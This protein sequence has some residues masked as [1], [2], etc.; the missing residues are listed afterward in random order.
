M[1]VSYETAF[2]IAKQKVSHDLRNTSQTLHDDVPCY[3]EC[4]VNETIKTQ[5]SSGDEKSRTREE[6]FGFLQMAQPQWRS[7][8]RLH[9]KLLNKKF[10]T[11]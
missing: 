8:M 3:S 9:S 10:H 6:G 2:E 4:R 11:I 5:A 7:H 1:E